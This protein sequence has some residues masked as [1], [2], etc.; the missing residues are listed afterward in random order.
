MPSTR[1][2]V[3]HAGAA[4]GRGHI[5]RDITHALH[6]AGGD[7][8]GITGLDRLFRQHH[9][10]QAGAADL[11]DG[12]SAA[13]HGQA[14]FDHGLTPGILTQADRHNIAHNHFVNQGLVDAGP[15][16]AATDSQG[17]EFGGR[18]GG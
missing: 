8:F 13:G 15:L 7:Y 3:A 11:V 9:R 6:T 12:Y 5:V 4:A 1:G 17:A 16:D 18:K 14:G 2:A 10:L